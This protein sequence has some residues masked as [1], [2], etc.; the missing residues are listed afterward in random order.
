MSLR[1]WLLQEIVFLTFN[2]LVEVNHHM[3]KVIGEA[4]PPVV[5]VEALGFVHI[6]AKLDTP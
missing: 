1:Y 4:E 6:V 5:V 3:A 2:L